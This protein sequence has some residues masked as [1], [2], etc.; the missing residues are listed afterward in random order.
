MQI[1][2]NNFMFYKG[3]K[4]FVRG[5]ALSLCIFAG[6]SATTDSISQTNNNYSMVSK[7]DNNPE[8]ILDEIEDYAGI[9][10]N[11]NYNLVVLHAIINNNRLDEEEKAYFYQ[12]V[13]LISE[14]PYIDKKMTYDSLYNLD[15]VY[16]GKPNEYDDTILALYSENENLIKVFSKREDLNKEIFLHELIHTLFTNEKT[17]NLPKFILEGETELLTNEYLSEN[18]FLE[19]NTY[20]F[21]VAMVK[22]LCEMVGADEILK[23][24]TTGDIESLYKKLDENSNLDS[25]K[26]IDNVDKVFTAFTEKRIVPAEIYNEMIVYLDNYMNNNYQICSEKIEIY[27]YYKGILNKIYL[28][29]PYLKYEKYICE[30]G[31]ILKPYYSKLL[32]EEYTMQERKPIKKSLVK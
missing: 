29:N 20:P 6:L 13:D 16:T 19:K 27:E 7:I 4:K 17:I 14:N 24:Y 30:N 32:K 1:H 25:R 9:E 23:T 31:I 18:P 2:K 28:D 5:F 11:D 3:P 15:I 21:E 22:L 8:Y 10:T 12:L 26:F